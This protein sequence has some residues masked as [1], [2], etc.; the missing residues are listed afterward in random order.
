[1]NQS[2]KTLSTLQKISDSPFYAAR[3][4]GDYG[5]QGFINGA[6]KG[7]QDVVPFFEKLFMRRGIP[8]SISPP[9]AIP[10]IPA[11]SAFYAANAVDGPLVGKNLDWKKSPI[12]L[13]K[14]KQPGFLSAFSIVDLSLC[15]LFGM[16]SFVHSLARAPYVPFDGMNESG[17]VVTMLSVQD[18][19]QYPFDSQKTV[20]GDFNIIRIIL[21]TCTTV[22]MAIECFN[23][24]S[25]V[26]TGP[27]P[28]H[29]L[30]ADLNKSI[31]VEFR[32]GDIKITNL[33]KNGVVTNNLIEPASGFQKNR[34]LCD[35]FDTL[36]IA[37]E[38]GEMLTDLSAKKLLKKVSVYR[39][40]FQPPSTIWSVLYC[41]KKRSMKVKPGNSKE[42]F[43]VSL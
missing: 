39:E 30:I 12:L 7:P 13:L 41:P 4:C 20:V 38:S 43:R 27:L 24:F 31:V 6:I 23:R 28:I 16:N 14:T 21:D 2:E 33:T 17:L 26:Q 42:Y 36:F 15:E 11:C 5:I 40:D 22:E 35:R 25:V 32:N 29:Y 1:M 19:C 34:A 37:I 10:E 9:R 18:S 3:Y 8:V